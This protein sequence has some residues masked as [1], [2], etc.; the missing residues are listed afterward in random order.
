MIVRSELG[1]ENLPL[2]L[3]HLPEHQGS[4]AEAKGAQ[5]AFWGYGE[6]RYRRWGGGGG[7]GLLVC[8]REKLLFF[9]VFASLVF[10]IFLGLELLVSIFYFIFLAQ[11]KSF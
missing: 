4:E 2:S 11:K 8:A 5:E 6:H 9:G 10:V 1:F 7:A 3:R